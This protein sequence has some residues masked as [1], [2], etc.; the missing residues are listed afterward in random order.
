MLNLLL[1]PKF[2]LVLSELLAWVVS[3]LGDERDLG[4]F[5]SLSTSTRNDK[6]W[7]TRFNDLNKTYATPEAFSPFIPGYDEMG[8]EPPSTDLVRPEPHE[9]NMGTDYT[10]PRFNRGN[11]VLEFAFVPANE[12]VRPRTGVVRHRTWVW[13]P[14][15]PPLTCDMCR[16]A[17]RQHQKDEPNCP[18]GAQACCS[19]VM[20]TPLA[21]V[22]A[23]ASLLHTF[24]DFIALTRQRS[25]KG[26]SG[27]ELVVCLLLVNGMGLGSASCTCA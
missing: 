1:Q 20:L 26:T 25:L 14:K 17:F 23:R 18:R 12:P 3:Y 13:V 8:V 4:A 9:N 27:F 5:A 24:T 11:G 6:V 10:T 2:A 21:S 19:D 7:T 22:T 16:Y 15:L